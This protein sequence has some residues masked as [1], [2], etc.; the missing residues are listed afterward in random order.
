MQLI[1]RGPPDSRRGFLVSAG[2]GPRPAHSHRGYLRARASAIH[3]N[4]S[5]TRSVIS[6]ARAHGLPRRGALCAAAPRTGS[7]A[8]RC[9]NLGA[10]STERARQRHRKALTRSSRLGAG[11]SRTVMLWMPNEPTDEVSRIPVSAR[12]ANCHAASSKVHEPTRIPGTRRSRARCVF[13][14]GAERVA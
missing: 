14:R 4:A 9:R 5:E 2:Q 6:A 7:P 11:C 1:D 10:M 8:R 3:L 12:L 13:A